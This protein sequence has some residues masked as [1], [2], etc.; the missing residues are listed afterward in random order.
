MPGL[1]GQAF[2]VGGRV[3][4]ALL[5]AA[6]ALLLV[7][8]LGL[9][10]LS[11]R[12]AEG[13]MHVPFLTRAVEQMIARGGLQRNVEVSDIVL[14]WDGFRGGVASPLAV[15]VSGLR[16]RDETGALRQELPDLSVSF[17]LA[18]LLVGN[19]S[20]T[21][22]TLRDPAIVLERDQ[23]GDVSLAMGHLD[24]GADADPA[25]GKLLEELLD[26]SGLFS[27][28][29]S[30]VIT[31]GRLTILDRQ[32]HL[33]WQMQGVG[34]TLRRV[35]R[36]GAEG[37][38]V[39]QLV[40]PGGGGTVPVR[41]T[42]K[43]SNKGPRVEGRLEV[44][45]LEPA[46]L[47]GL[48]PALAPLGLVNASV[49]MDVH[50]LL[51][52]GERG[53]PQ[54]TL[55]L[56]VGEG[57]L[58]LRPGVRVPF[59]GMEL[60]ASGSPE[61]LRLERLA[62]TLP[63]VL[64]QPQSVPPVIN[65][66]GQAALRQ[67]R[68][69]GDLALA[70]NR[71][72][73]S[74]LGAYWPA[75]LAANARHWVVENV[76]AGVANG[77]NFKLAAESAEDLSGFRLTEAAGTLQVEQATVHWL[78]PVPP[79]ENVTGTVRLGLKEVLVQANSGRQA[80]TALNASGVTVRL[81][82]LDTDAEQMEITGRLRGPVA[83]A[84]NLIRHPRLKLF[85]KRPLDL[86][87]PGG[88]L[89]ATL[90][91]ATPL[92]VDLPADAIRVSVQAHL[93]ALRLADVVAGQ[94]LQR[95]TA[96]LTVDN[97]R[98]RATGDAQV[99]GIP[100]KLSV[101][102]DFRPGPA[103]QVVERVQASGRTDIASLERFGLDL[104]GL[105][106]GP[107]SVEAVMEKPRSGETR[108]DLRGDL[109]DATMTL[110]P[111]AWR[112]PPGQPATARAELRAMGE[113]LRSLRNL[114]V[115]APQLSLRGGGSFTQDNRLQ[116]LDLEDVALGRSRFGGSLRA[117]ASK[118]GAWM[119]S[120]RGPVLDLMPAL[121]TEKPAQLAAAPQARPD[122]DPP[123][124]I[125]VEGRF[126]R[127]LLDQNRFLTGVQGQIRA[128]GSGTLRQG[129]VSGRVQN[130]A[131]FDVAVTPRGA[132]RDLHLTSEDAGALLAAFDVLHQ[133]RG[134]RLSVNAH[135]ANNRPDAVLSG[136]AE[137]QDFSVLDAPAV[138]KLLQALTVYGVFDAVQG[139]GLAFSHLNAP[140]SLSPQ[141]LTVRD[142][143]AFSPS[144]GVTVKGEMNRVARS[145]AFDGT[146]VPAYALNTVLG[147]LP[148]VG[149]LFSPE[150]G[151][152]LFAAA[153]K[154]TGPV[155]N[156]NVSVNPLSMLTPGFLRGLFGSGQPAAP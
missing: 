55:G 13:P 69:R 11:W 143:H 64:G 130:N 132:G 18:R 22:V 61:D 66:T 35:G 63:P 134:G 145:L 150:K 91:L 51:D 83:D 153:F 58:A 39:A 105:A 151:G 93:T 25:S 74:A 129:R 65:A 92:L 104:E 127:V 80:G 101:E 102:M 12:L 4:S 79:V 122:P 70:L 99:G 95:G 86:K 32:L 77:G 120:L 76:T 72:E 46:R 33:T 27:A 23:D 20:L 10:A 43:A 114:R 98:L 81:F 116:Q 125:V 16:V 121:T 21:E 112:K 148:L 6:M 49:S 38:G 53:S 31:N 1:T 47:A 156:P 100:A 131:P 141:R 113:N 123:A 26:G 57:N 142:A 117:P 87:Q 14:A 2:R 15:R 118:G 75:D 60:H 154:V 68:W 97:G 155:D 124:D 78:R 30:I 82:A 109:Q 3:C 111:L 135:W 103:N 5:R 108:V 136:T 149:R 147:R 40:L 9:A 36:D 96:D 115:E 59:K 52:G 37:E 85:E 41:L 140:F 146:I 94:D 62:L 73:V 133:V 28:L 34:L 138:G 106:A 67:G 110:T 84:V 119:I 137:L 54:L 126:D 17:S 48:M 152:G 56:R 139:P 88:Q 24:D 44:P 71:M 42:G 45:A 19:I 144:L 29:R 128:D 50:G 90:R 107:V 89:D 8:G 7:V